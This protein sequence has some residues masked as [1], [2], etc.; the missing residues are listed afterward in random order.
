MQVGSVHVRGRL[1]LAAMEEHTT[2]PFRLI[3]KEFGAALV[4]TEMVQ[5]DRLVAGD[6][7]AQKLLATEPREKPIGGQVL[8]GDEAVTARACALVAEKG[9]DLV[10]VNA[11]CPI[12]RVVE[13]SWGGAY[14]RDPARLEALVARCAAAV[15]PKPLTVKMRIGFDDARPNAPE[16]AA[17]AEA[18]GAAAVIVHARSVE[19]AYRGGADWTLLKETKRAVTVPVI[20]AG[21]VRTP[22]DAKRLL[23]ETGCDGVLLARGALGNPWIFSRASRLLEEGRVPAPPT[24]EERIR[25]LVRH[26]EAEARFLNEKKPSARLLRLAFYYAKDLPDFS[27][28]QTAARTARSIPELVRAL[29][30]AFR[31]RAIPE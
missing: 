17:R 15:R 12:K 29:K 19:R 18:A 20:G 3:A 22:E 8:A 1:V 5:P 7:M 24:R 2:L 16:V 13:R 27:R 23:D 14:L 30:D 6:R 21:D 9:F 31:A 26:L 28:I 4:F 10:D 11:S 25:I